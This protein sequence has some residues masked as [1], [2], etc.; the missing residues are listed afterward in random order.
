MALIFVF[1]LTYFFIAQPYYE[2]PLS[3]IE[4]VC[5]VNEETSFILYDSGVYTLYC[6]GERIA[7]ISE[8]DLSNQSMKTIPVYEKNKR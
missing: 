8:D 7:N 3:T 5:V 1:A 4:G 2:P 6:E